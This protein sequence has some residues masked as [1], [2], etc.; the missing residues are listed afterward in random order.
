MADN[1]EDLVDKFQTL[2]GELRADPAQI[3]GSD[4]VEIATTLLTRMQQ[5]TAEQQKFAE[6]LNETTILKER[7]TLL[8]ERENFLLRVKEGIRGS[9]LESTKQNLQM[10]E[11]A[12]EQNTS[13]LEIVQEQVMEYGK[14]TGHITDF[15]DIDQKILDV[16]IEKAKILSGVTELTDEL[17]QKQLG[18]LEGQRTQLEVQKSHEEFLKRESMLRERQR[19]LFGAQVSKFKDAFEDAREALNSTAGRI[20]IIGTALAVIGKRLLDDFQKIRA[21]AGTTLVQTAQLGREA[22][23]GMGIA[24]SEGIVASDKAAAAAA[25]NLAAQFGRVDLVTGQS[26]A[27]VLR[28][29]EVTGLGVE[30]ASRLVSTIE[31]LPNFTPEVAQDFIMTADQIARINGLAPAQL[32]QTLAQHSSAIAMHGAAGAEHFIKAAAAVQRMGVDLSSIE[33][34]ADRALDVES[35]IREFTRLRTLGIDLGDPLGLAQIAQTGDYEALANELQARLAGIGRELTIEGLGGRLQA[36]QLAEALGIPFEQLANMMATAGEGA[37]RTAEDLTEE[38]KARLQARTNMDETATSLLKFA[39]SIGFAQ[40]AVITF[41][42]TTLAIAAKTGL[43]GLLGRIPGLGRLLTGA[44]TTA[45]AIGG[46][47]LPGL[48]SNVPAAAAT[49][50]GG[51]A[52]AGIGGRLAG[53]ARFGT[54]L[55]R[56]APLV[57][58]AIAAGSEIAQGGGVGRAAARGVGTTAG[59]LIGQA[60]IPIPV[61]GA[62]IGAFAGD[63]ITKKII[64]PGG[65]EEAAREA[66]EAGE[67]EERMIEVDMSGVE[68][69][70]D[71]LIRLFRTGVISVNMDGKKVGKL[72]AQ[73]QPR[74]T[75]SAWVG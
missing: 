75:T 37:I 25:G 67:P 57:G 55:A 65:A 61:V 11:S 30:E 44:G 41:G 26:I 34:F 3:I 56:G 17:A 58:G 28:L 14:I 68:E 16:D 40:G 18:I 35:M 39:S 50:A 20:G 64:G 74:D 2:I 42:A 46:R 48:I 38:E 52:L 27:N 70:L 63:W 22:I 43:G 66:K 51:G 4:Q 47:A 1:F 19:Q 13:L 62:A 6:S 73:A 8:T 31:R 36:K 53:L 7:N 54:R 72:V 29:T 32:F 21:S 23:R 33:R 9:E 69:K 24:F 15:S 59:A 12:I 60:A 10:L 45:T 5:R 71:H 49:T